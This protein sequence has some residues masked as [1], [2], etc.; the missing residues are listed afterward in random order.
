MATDDAPNPSS[1]ML[2]FFILTTIYSVMQYNA[3]KQ[4]AS[5]DTAADG[6]DSAG[7]MYFMIYLLSVIIGQFF[8]N[9]QLT[10]AMCGSPNWATAAMCTFFPW[11]FIFGILLL[12]LSMFPGWL[13]P[14]SNTFGYGVALAAGLNDT[15]VDILKPQSKKERD[16]SGEKLNPQAEEALEHI[17]ADRSLLVNEIT[18]DNFDNFWNNM[19]GLFRSGVESNNALKSDLYSF[20][21]LKEI[22][23]EYVWYILAGM[24]ITSVSFNYIAGSACGV[25]A[26]EM[27]A[28]HADYEKELKAAQDDAKAKADNQRVYSTT[29]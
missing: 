16:S 29:E 25:S 28:R 15:M 9:L 24:L 17:Y 14:F 13:A 7:K 18:S 3:S 6:K 5:T 11:G 21:V 1:A 26:G 10:T 22:V 4:Y 27:Q 19:A 8:I 2:L 23:S 12:L 20:V